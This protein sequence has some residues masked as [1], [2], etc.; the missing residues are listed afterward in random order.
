MKLVI[1]IPEEKYNKLVMEEEHIRACQSFYQC[2]IL[3][4]IPL[5]EVK[6]KIEKDYQKRLDDHQRWLM[7]EEEQEECI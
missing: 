1:D 6:S 4:G 3:D 5:D 2:M 7:D